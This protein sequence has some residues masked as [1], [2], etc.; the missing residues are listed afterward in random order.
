MEEEEEEKKKEQR[1]EEEDE[2]ENS[3]CNAI[4]MRANDI[5]SSWPF[6]TTPSPR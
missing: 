6:S 1:A 5:V 4:W 2:R 3:C